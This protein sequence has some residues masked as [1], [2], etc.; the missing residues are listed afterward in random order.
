MRYNT[1][2]YAT[3]LLH[4]IK[5]KYGKKRQDALRNFIQIIRKNRDFT[6]LASIIR[7]VERQYLQKTGFKKIEIESAVPISREIKKEISRLAG[8]K[9]F[10][11]ESTRQEL[12]A[13]IKIM[14]NEEFLID[15]S[16]K[17]QIKKFFAR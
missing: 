13:G 11:E 17:K 2:Q 9:V 5:D 8:E 10:I 6:R 16:A 3:A 1:R 4:V 7:E 12:L 15:A 14:I